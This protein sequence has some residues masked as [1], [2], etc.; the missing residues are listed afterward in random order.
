MTAAAG[1]VVAMPQGIS[2]A[3][4]AKEPFKMLLTVIRAAQQ[5]PGLT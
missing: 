5:L 4:E 3:L 1:E 2:H